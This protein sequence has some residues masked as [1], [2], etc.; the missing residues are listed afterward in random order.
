V[1][2]AGVAGAVPT[3]VSEV[4]GRYG[5]IGVNVNVPIF[6]GHLFKARQTEAELRAQAAAQTLRDLDNR[7]R[8][9]V[10]VA[11]LNATTA[12]QRIGLT[13]ELLA[14]AR[15]AADL[16]QSR[17]DIGLGT[18]VEL[19]QAQLNVTSAEIANST[20]VFD[21]QAERANLAYQMG[22]LR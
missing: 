9:D 5:A 8:R 7:I 10:E 14:D 22:A 4:P 3:G 2:V 11:Y 15:M 16:A 20:A 18:I 1:G 12:F 19:S 17:Y 13:A 21:Y 6:N